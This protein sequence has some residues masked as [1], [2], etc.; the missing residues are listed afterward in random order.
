MASSQ[1]GTGVPSGSIAISAEE[2][3]GQPVVIIVP[4]DRQRGEYIIS[5]R[6]RCGKRIEHF[7]TIRQRK[8]GSLID[9]SMTVL[10]SDRGRKPTIARK[11]PRYPEDGAGDGRRP[12]DDSKDQRGELAEGK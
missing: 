10:P 2:A 11:R 6:A 1:A 8:D 9:I 4:P 3:I 12:W 5:E 7:E